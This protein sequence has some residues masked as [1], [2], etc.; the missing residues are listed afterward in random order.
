MKSALTWKGPGSAFA[1]IAAV[2]MWSLI[3]AAGSS[4]AE[5]RGPSQA[6][7]K[8]AYLYNLAKFV[9]WPDR[10]FNGLQ[11]PFVLGILGDDPFDDAFDRVRGKAVKGRTFVVKKF[12]DVHDI[13]A[14]HILFISA[15]EKRRWRPIFQ[16]LQHRPILLA[17]D[18]EGFAE[19][20]GIVN[21]I[22]L[23]RNV[24][25][26]VNADAAA[27][28]GLTFSSRIMNIARIVRG[29]PAQEDE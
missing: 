18:T 22:V 21:F 5:E 4:F 10:A 20:G 7:I 14:S 9:E 24:S 1:M 28:S 12:N 29:A 3:G 8:A 2:V 6:Q 16:A 11:E 19:A 23:N 17:G 15:S 13:K 25:I 27:R 26:E